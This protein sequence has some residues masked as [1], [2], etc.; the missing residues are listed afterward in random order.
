MAMC[1]K[2]APMDALALQYAVGNST[3]E[4]KQ[5]KDYFLHLIQ[6]QNVAVENFAGYTLDSVAATSGCRSLN[7][8]RRGLGSSRLNPYTLTFTFKI[9]TNAITAKKVR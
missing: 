5:A 4:L 6:E 7:E 9:T 2:L 1:V 3:A 8:R